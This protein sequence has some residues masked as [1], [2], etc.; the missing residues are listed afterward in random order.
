VATW[1]YNRPPAQ[2][3][4]TEFR[5]AQLLN[6]LSDDWLIRWGYY[7][8]TDRE[9]DFLVFGP[10]GGLL[11]LEVKG[12]PMRKL[13]TTGKRARQLLAVHAQRK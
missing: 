2:C 7:Y 13:A 4:E 5:V 11:V 1:I 12:A 6:R 8:D 9:G 10:N 3:D